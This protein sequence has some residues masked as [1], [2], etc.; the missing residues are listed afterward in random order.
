MPRR[1]AGLSRT[2]ALP[3]LNASP[4]ERAERQHRTWGHTH[5]IPTAWT[6]SPRLQAPSWRMVPRHVAC[7]PEPRPPLA[8]SALKLPSND[9]SR[10]VPMSWTCLDCWDQPSLKPASRLALGAGWARTSMWPLPS[11]T[12]ARPPICPWPG[13]P[14]W[15]LSDHG[16]HS[17]P[18]PP[19][20]S[21]S[22]RKAVTMGSVFSHCCLLGQGPRGLP[23]SHP[24]WKGPSWGRRC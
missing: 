12:Q 11:S 9:L 20:L 15:L 6:T 16:A 23:C 22:T 10:E 1:Q 24:Q 8:D 13:V 3:P 19:V 18:A 5:G 17:C 14:G 7:P 21:A 4:A 2:Y